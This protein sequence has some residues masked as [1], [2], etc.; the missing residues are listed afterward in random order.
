MPHSAADLCHRFADLV[1]ESR[2]VDCE[3]ER[4]DSPESFDATSLIFVS[5]RASLPDRSIGIP[6]VLVTDATIAE[7][8]SPQDCVVVTK[9][10]R[11]AQALIKQ[12]YQDYDA[13]DPEW[14]AIHPTAVIHPSAKLSETVRVGANSVIG[15]NVTIGNETIIR[16]NC[17][18]ESGAQ[19]GANCILNNLVNIG[20]GCLLGDRVIVR[21]GAIIG[22][23]G[24][25]FAQDDQRH[26]QRVPHTGN[27]VLEDDVQI[28]ANCTIDRATYGTTLIKRGVKIDAL[29]HIAHN[30]V[31]GEDAL[32]VAQ[33]GVAGSCNIGERVICSGQT[34]MLDH[35]TVA[36]D[37]V[38]VHR[39]GVTED[40]PSAGLWA[41]TPPKPFKEY[42]ANLNAA[43]RLEKKIARLQAQIDEL[44]S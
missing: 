13:S 25:G 14:D 40:I 28:G 4:I 27:V 2:N 20:I 22:G 37:A 24:F 41:G 42:V 39:C 11:L 10:V 26:Y 8:V 3:F 9:N 17:V 43:R 1:I 30:C 35:R 23:E 38:L 31:V 7:D 29:C 21:S 44:K 36:A 32:F 16:A 33:S 34:G 18:V 6:A 12:Y 15:A 5:E 19:V